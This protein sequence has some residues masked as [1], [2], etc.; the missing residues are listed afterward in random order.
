[1]SWS[2]VRGIVDAATQ[3]EQQRK[4]NEAC[5]DLRLALRRLA[6]T[7]ADYRAGVRLR[8]IFSKALLP[9]RLGQARP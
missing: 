9:R 6:V 5:H 2:H 3:I 4:S 1:M 8:W 7:L